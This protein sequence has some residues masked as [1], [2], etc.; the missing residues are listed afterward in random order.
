VTRSVR[1][2]AADRVRTEPVATVLP[3]GVPTPR[4]PVP[5]VG[6]P[7]QRRPPAFPRPLTPVEE[8]AAVLAE[9][10]LDGALDDPQL[11]AALHAQVWPPLPPGRPAGPDGVAVLAQRYRRALAATLPPVLAQLRAAADEHLPL[12]AGSGDACDFCP[13]RRL[14]ARH[15]VL[16]KTWWDAR[17]PLVRAT[18]HDL[19]AR[20]AAALGG[21]PR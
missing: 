4:L 1:S 17:D 10:W 11:L 13:P 7:A 5:A 6:P 8:R 16:V 15:E 14:C 18:V 2:R 19:P 12:L 3:A 9:R 21:T 20:A